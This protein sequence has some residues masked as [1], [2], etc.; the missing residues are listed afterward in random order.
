MTQVAV[1]VR[2]TDPP[3]HITLAGVDSR[4]DMMYRRWAS[5]WRDDPKEQ[6]RV[7]WENFHRTDAQ[8]NLC[9]R[10][11]MECEKRSPNAFEPMALGNGAGWESIDPFKKHLIIYLVE[12]RRKED[13]AAG[14]PPM[15]FGFYVGCIGNSMPGMISNRCM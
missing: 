9:Q 5:G 11:M 6:E 8:G 3:F 4:T 15:S 13:A 14:R 2:P 7:L 10:V 1:P 12:Q